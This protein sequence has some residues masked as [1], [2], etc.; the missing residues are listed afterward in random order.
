MRIKIKKLNESAVIPKYATDGSAGLDLTATSCEGAK[1]YGFYEYGTGLSFEIPD[2]YVGL[3]FPRSSIS[4]TCHFLRNAV[5]V[6]DSDFRGEVKLRFSVEGDMG[7]DAY[8]IGDKI[9]QLI[10]IPYPQVVW[11]VVDELSETERGEGGFGSS[12]GN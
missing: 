9:G 3:V 10:V 1:Y 7:G 2:G 6:L 12:D 5:A 11:E 8:K 4:K